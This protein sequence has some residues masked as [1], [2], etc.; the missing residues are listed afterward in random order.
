MAVINDT[1]VYSMNVQ[2]SSEIPVIGADYD[3]QV[4]YK[5]PAQVSDDAVFQSTDG[6]EA[7]WTQLNGLIANGQSLTNHPLLASFVQTLLPL[8]KQNYCQQ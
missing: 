2:P 7:M 8:L 5:G 1:T 6:W 3:V 4:F